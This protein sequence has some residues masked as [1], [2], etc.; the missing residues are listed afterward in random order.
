MPA[1]DDRPGAD[2]LPFDWAALNAQPGPP[3]AAP[4]FEV[5]YL[6]TQ[7]RVRSCPAADGFDPAP[8]GARGPGVSR[9][10]P[11]LAL[12]DLVGALARP[13][14]AGAGAVPGGAELVGH[15]RP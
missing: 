3:A 11:F 7:N 8:L 12:V 13:A 4:R 15:L 9:G 10:G 14:A 1:P 5:A 2:H 6:P